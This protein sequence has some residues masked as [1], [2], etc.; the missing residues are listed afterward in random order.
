MSE[1]E[2]IDTPKRQKLNVEV[3]TSAFDDINFKVITNDGTASS[4]EAL[5]TLKNI[6]SRQLPK[7]PKEYI[8]RLIFDYRHYSLAICR[9]TRIIGGIW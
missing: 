1:S 3:E 4:S 2:N 8:V 7:M 5:I 9:G 6:I